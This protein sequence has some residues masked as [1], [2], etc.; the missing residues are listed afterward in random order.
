MLPV[1]AQRI[2]RTRGHLGG[3]W[4]GVAVLLLF[5][6]GVGLSVWLLVGLA[7]AARAPRRARGRRRRRRQRARLGLADADVPDARRA[8]PRLL[9]PGPRRARQ[10]AARGRRTTLS[11][12]LQ[13]ING[14]RRGRRHQLQ[15]VR[16]RLLE[17]GRR[18]AARQ[19]AGDEAEHGQR[20]GERQRPRLPAGLLRG[21]GARLR[22]DARR[23]RLDARRADVHA[24]DRR[25]AGDG[26]RARAA[27]DAARAVPGPAAADRRRGARCARSSPC[28]RGS[29]AV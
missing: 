19:G 22:R 24:R 9:R 21:A 12:E 23:R 20:R 11:A 14:A 15:P 6:V 7:R 4:R 1:I 13:L 27:R 8:L 28:S 29:R 2:G 17:R 26:D 3:A 10:A 18:P 5:A 25:P 16:P